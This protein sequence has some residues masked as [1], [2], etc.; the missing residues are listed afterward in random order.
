MFDK[1]NVKQDV[2][3]AKIGMSTLSLVSRDNVNESNSFNGCEIDLI[4]NMLF[5]RVDVIPNL[6]RLCHIFSFN[7]FIMNK[8]RFDVL[9]DLLDSEN[10]EVISLTIQVLNLVSS[11][12]PI[13]NQFAVAKSHLD[14]LFSMLPDLNFYKVLGKI[15]STN[16]KFSGYVME[17]KNISVLADAARNDSEMLPIFSWFISCMVNNQEIISRLLPYYADI[18]IPNI[19]SDNLFVQ[20]H[21]LDSVRE[22]SLYSAEGCVLIANSTQFQHL[23]DNIPEEPRVCSIFIRL[24]QNI[25]RVTFLPNLEN[26]VLKLFSSEEHNI[27]QESIALYV[28]LISDRFDCSSHLEV[29][30]G[31]VLNS[32]IFFLSVIAARAICQT[33]VYS[34]AQV[35]R[36]LSTHG[37]LESFTLL[38]E[39]G[40]QDVLRET[41]CSVQEYTNT[42]NN[43]YLLD[44]ISKI[45][46]VN[47]LDI[48]SLCL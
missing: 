5:K 20:R 17:N 30:L 22:L 40:E 19:N 15:I 42:M 35:R 32:S 25:S 10:S 12:S 36:Y 14:K 23:L 6:Q 2:K 28:S 43:F 7:Q 41:V 21:A 16:I 3:N 47:D 31:F 26:V 48:S 38:T 37:L 46:F 33:F 13:F 4:F 8:F 44:S 18:I 9:L 29:L 27:L 39:V 11:F 34:S 45:L 1:L 24:L